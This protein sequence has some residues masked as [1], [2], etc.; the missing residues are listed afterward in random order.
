M[1][2]RFHSTIVD[3]IKNICIRIAG[4]KGVY[5]VALSGGVFMNEFLLVNTIIA[6]QECGLKPFYQQTV[7]SN[8]GGISMGQIMIADALSK[9][10]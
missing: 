4:N 1:S 9:T 2:R 10:N 8:D 5:K 6:L 7:P 3:A